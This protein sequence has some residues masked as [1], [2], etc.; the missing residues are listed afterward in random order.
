MDLA[1]IIVVVIIFAFVGYTFREPIEA[2]Y[3]WVQEQIA[4]ASGDQG[5]RYVVVESPYYSFSAN[6]EAS[7]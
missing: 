2:V 7:Q 5:P 4:K 1:S 3:D 6:R